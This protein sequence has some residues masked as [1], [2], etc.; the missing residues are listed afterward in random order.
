MKTEQELGQ[1]IATNIRHIMVEKKYN[2]TELA[3]KTGY[4]KNTVSDFLLNLEQGKGTFKTICKYANA[5]EVSPYT[6]FYEIK[7]VPRE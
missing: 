1:V 3:K 7:M 6:L 5:L 4:A 2:L